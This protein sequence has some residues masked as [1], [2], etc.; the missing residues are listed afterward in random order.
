MARINI[1][2]KNGTSPG[3]IR[4]VPAIK[5]VRGFTGLGL[6]DAKNIVD[7]ILLT[8]MSATILSDTTMSRAKLT[9][10]IGMIEDGGLFITAPFDEDDPTIKEIT[11]KTNELICFAN[12]T[13]HYGVSKALV[14]ML[15]GNFP[16]N[17]RG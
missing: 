8:N 11:K 6:K 7:N 10:Y 13:G 12:I 9:E 16:T 5:G 4:K 3:D 14:D 1:Y 17:L 15:D 2:M